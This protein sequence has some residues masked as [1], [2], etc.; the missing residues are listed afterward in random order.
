MLSEGPVTAIYKKHVSSQTTSQVFPGHKPIKSINALNSMTSSPNNRRMKP[1]YL[2]TLLCRWTSRAVVGLSLAAAGPLSA[3]TV[4]LM[5][6]SFESAPTIATGLDDYSTAQPVGPGWLTTD[7]TPVD[8]P[9]G[10]GVQ[11][12]NWLVHSGQKALF[13]RPGTTTQYHFTNVLSG[14][15]YQLDFW[16]YAHKE[17]TSDRN[18]K[19]D[20]L[21]ECAD[22]GTGT[23]LSYISDRS[24][25]GFAVMYYN[26][27]GTSTAGY[28]SNLNAVYLNDTWQHHRIVFDPNRLK[29]TSYID[30]MTTPV[31]EDVNT[32]GAHFNMPV[33]LQIVHE[34]NTLDDGYFA[35]DDVVLTVDN[36]RDLSSTFTEGFETYPART[37]ETDA[38]WPLGPWITTTA[39]NGST[40]MTAPTRVQ[41]VGTD[42]VAPHSG[43]KCLK[44][45]GGQ[46]AGVS[47][48]WGTPPQQDVQITWWVKI[49]ASVA[50]VGEK[51]YLR[52]SLYAAED[53][54]NLGGDTANLAYGARTATLGDATS[55][56]TWCVT[57]WFDTGSTYT[58]DTWEE[59]QLTTYQNQRTYSIVKNPS[60]KPETVVDRCALI[61]GTAL[62]FKPVFM[63]A[64]SS[65]NGSGHPPVYLDDIEVRSLVATP[66]PLP[67]LPYNFA[68][69]GTRFTN[70]TV[71]NV[72][73]PAGPVAIDPRDGSTIIYGAISTGTNGGI[74][75][76]HKTARAQWTVDAQPLLTS[77][78]SLKGL[79]V[80]TNGT[81]WW[82]HNLTAALCRLPAPWTA[83]YPDTVIGNFGYVSADDDP[84]DVCVAPASF[85]GSLAAP[86]TI[87]IGDAGCD[88]NAYNA[89]YY[90]D[91]TTT[92][93]NQ[94][95]LTDFLVPPDKSLIG[96]ND[97]RQISP[98]PTSGEVVTISDQPYSVISAVDGNG[99][100][101]YIVPSTTFKTPQGIVADPVTGRLWVL[102][103]G[104]GKL[105]SIESRN[106][107]AAS[108][109]VEATFTNT[110]VF[111]STGKVRPDFSPSFAGPCMAFAPD[112]KF[113]VV[114]DQ[115]ICA[116]GSRLLIFHN[117]S[118]PATPVSFTG[119]TRTAAGVQLS[120]EAEA[121]ATFHV[122]RAESIK[123]TF[124]DIS[125]S[126]TTP[127]FTDANPPA[128]GAFYRIVVS[129]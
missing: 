47:Y 113:L 25:N 2:T 44:L 104:T 114:S 100:I 115:S 3:A 81:I 12:E 72:V 125:G 63:I 70:L 90:L 30:D 6:E 76:L 43:T 118:M 11:V 19:I 105:W 46:R 74:Y 66:E 89:V 28:T 109:R 96:T 124:S 116:E 80:D 68:M 51:V 102:D 126:L 62:N 5:N 14:T 54:N 18:F 60:T 67:T 77:I 50:K 82:T 9:L 29:M 128:G 111:G 88:D 120:W 112:G 71:V 1:Y 55:M 78:N 21:G 79:T 31:Y 129:R 33:V 26:G 7:N 92:T 20:L 57:G 103:S 58:P 122:Q 22:S 73:G 23:A 10:S 40:A 107:Q 61:G 117:D 15:K 98:L 56:E 32:Y 101:R 39:T 99:T 69:M 94:L 108:D 93:T 95:G 48:A 27:V 49:P 37:N 35:I 123:G 42:V 24:T 13:L 45:E 75:S 41:V 119:I 97:L 34:G 65:S 36:S 64:F 110:A 86:G 38:A 91:P 84:N 83:G 127:T 17:A 59:Y 85:S 121:G 53:G 16:L 8:T 87:L 4:T 52:A 106:G